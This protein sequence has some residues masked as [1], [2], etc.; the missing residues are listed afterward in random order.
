MLNISR[1]KVRRYN[2]LLKKGRYIIIAQN[3][4]EM[5]KLIN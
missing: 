5:H 2:I 3:S 1:V 4:Q